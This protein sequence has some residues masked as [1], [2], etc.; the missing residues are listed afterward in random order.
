MLAPGARL[1]RATPQAGVHLQLASSWMRP[2][3]GLHSAST[4]CSV[5]E[6]VVASKPLQSASSILS[7]CGTKI[8]TLGLRREP[9]PLPA[10]AA[11][12]AAAAVMP[13]A[14]SKSA[15]MAA[16]L[17]VPR[18]R[19]KSRSGCAA[20]SSRAMSLGATSSLVCQ[21][22]APDHRAKDNDEQSELAK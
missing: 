1:R 22:P 3:S 18:L 15:A 10:P 19:K 5:W 14:A 7:R 4:N 2:S 13:V 11:A 12:A 8:R 17:T 21:L 16:L 9:L 20:A 6:P